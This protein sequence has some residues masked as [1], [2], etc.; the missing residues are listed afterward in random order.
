MYVSINAEAAGTITTLRQSQNAWQVL[1][2]LL[3][4]ALK[5]AVNVDKRVLNL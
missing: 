2:R 3:D 4:S 5:G 1:K